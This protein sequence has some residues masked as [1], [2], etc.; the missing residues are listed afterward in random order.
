[1]EGKMAKAGIVIPAR[2]ERLSEFALAHGSHRSI[3]DGVCAM[4]LVSWIAGEK[5]SDHPECVCPVISA[6]VRSWNDALPDDER[7]SLLRPVLPKLIGTRGNKALEDLRALMC[8]DW[9][10]R[11]HTPAWLRLAGLTTH[12]EALAALPEITSFAQVPSIRGPLEAARV[13]ADAA[14][15][16][17]GDAAGAAAAGDALAPTKQ[18]LQQSAL[19]LID[20]MI[21]A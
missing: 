14:G 10:I 8:A 4:E 17:A 19:R 18:A 9:L 5:W 12:A 16:A 15:A 13:D 1:M 21:A 6:F 7:T 11:E 2:L 20:R 3:K